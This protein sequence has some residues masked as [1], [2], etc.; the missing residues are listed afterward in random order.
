MS[1]VVGRDGE[2]ARLRGDLCGASPPAVRV[3]SGMGGVGKT[4]LARAYAQRHRDDYRVIWWVR[5][6][7]PA[8][9]DTEFRDLLPFLLPPGQLARDIPDARSTA[10]SL[11][12]HR[13]DPWLLVLDNVPDAASATSLIPASGNGHVLITSQASHWP[14][15][16]GVVPITPLPLAAAIDLLT[17]LSPDPDRDTADTLARELDCL[18]LALAQAASFVHA[19][20]IDLATYLRIYRNR[21][22]ELHQEET[23]TDYPHTVATTWQLAMDRLPPTAATLLNVFAFLA[24]DAVP[25]D[26][27]MSANPDTIT[28]PDSLAPLLHPLLT[29]EL[30]LMRALGELRAFSLITTPATGLASIHRLVQAV[31]RTR[32]TESRSPGSHE[33]SAATG[34]LIDRAIPDTDLFNTETISTWKALQTHVR[35]LLTHLPSDQ[36]DTLSIRYS[37]ASWTGEAGDPIRARDMLAELLPLHERV[38][39]PNHPNTLSTRHSLASWTGEAGD[40]IRARDMLAELLPI[41]ER[42]LGPN[43]PHTLNNRHNLAY[44]T[45]ETGNPV[46]ARD[47][48]A[49]LLPLHE[50]VLG[51]NHPDTLSIRNNLASWTGE[52]G[53]PIRARDMLAELLPLHERVLGPDHPDTLNDRHNLAYR[54]GEAGDPASAR[55]MLA[56]L[57]PLRERVLGPNH[58]HTLATRRSLAHWTGE[59]G[60]PASAR[61]MLAELLPLRER[62]LGP[63]HPHTLS[64]RLSLA[65]WTGEAGDPASARDMLAELLPLRERVLGPNHP[66]TLETR[67]N[68]E[69][70]TERIGRPGDEEDA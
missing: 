32:L 57:L 29:D 53:D 54:T 68:L 26:L 58:P 49:E 41:D 12:S 69:Y 4:S 15:R 52:A 6:E 25:V 16:D 50:R 42:V 13:T 17:R 37:L 30:T 47:M 34:A 24:P 60:D 59:A 65:H 70:W 40:P 63:N 33:W 66:R 31:T 18:P 27:I 35:V 7:D 21:A 61:D 23:L 19:N 43:H 46:G 22:A 20:G 56:E 36:P 39:G 38:F 67:R 55:D 14:S 45:G 51:P 44:L 48:F 2:L 1:I 8:A 28:L 10:L 5:A 3:L 64:T 11:L 9:V 62:V